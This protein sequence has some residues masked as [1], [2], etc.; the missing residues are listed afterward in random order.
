MTI[1]IWLTSENDAAKLKDIKEELDLSNHTASKE[2]G[3]NPILK[4]KRVADE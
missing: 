3:L 1:L 2:G 4:T